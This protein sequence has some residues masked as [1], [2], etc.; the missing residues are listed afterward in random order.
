M[1]TAVELVGEI[2]G[3]ANTRSAALPGTESRSVV[4]FGG[5]Y[6][7]GPVRVDAAALAG[8]TERD[9]SIGFTM[10]VTYIF[11]AFKIQ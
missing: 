7:R 9:P 2:N 1:T 10:G 5:R 11:N 6:T 3:R 4:R 8:L